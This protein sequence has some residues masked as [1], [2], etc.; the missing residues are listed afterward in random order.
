MPTISVSPE[1][2]YKGLGRTMTEKEFDKLC[3]DY[4][5]ELEVEREDEEG[6]PSETGKLVYKVEIPA[7]RY[8][9]LCLEGLVRAL[10]VYLGDIEAPRF[11]HV[12]M[13]PEDMQQLTITP[14]TQSVRPFCVAA[15]LRGVEF[16]QD[17]Y[18]RFIDLQDKLHQNICRRRALVAIGTHDLATITGPFVYDAQKP[19]D[20][21]FVPLR[22]PKKDE[23]GNATN[24]TEVPTREYTAA[25]LM[26]E[27]EKDQQLKQYLHI[28][29][30]EEVYPVIRDANGVVL[31]LPPIINGNHSRITLDTKDVFIECTATDL[32]RAKIVLNMMVTMLPAKSIEPVHVTPPN[33]QE[34][35]VYPEFKYRTEKVSAGDIYRRMGIKKE[36]AT[37]EQLAALLTKMQLRGKLVDADAIEVEIPPTRPD[38]LHACDIWE[39]AAVAFGFD[40]IQA[41]QPQ[42][43]TAGKQQPI[44]K[45]SDHLRLITAQAGYAEALTFALCTRDDNFKNLRRPDDGKTACVIANPKTK[46]FQVA[47]TNLLAGLLRT[48]HN[49]S[50]MPLPIQLFEISDVVLLDPSSD[51]GASNE[52]RLAAVAMGKS[53]RFEALQGLL[54]YI[55]KMLE[56]PFDPSAVNPGSKAYCLLP[57]QDPAFLGELG[58]ADIVYNGARV[59]V[60][61]VVHPEVLQNFDLRYPVSAFELAVHPFL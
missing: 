60:L 18:E 6:R 24:E 40:N 32:T 30:D 12:D 42:V 1:A 39:D 16:T 59:G 9:L 20:I 27:Y 61:G 37:P 31:S 36:Q 22:V 10:R 17:V 3:F 28:I 13:K 50:A 29:K 34:S 11:K 7:N 45:L 26:V 41:T 53:P 52:R 54:D 2:L 56:I 8:D 14:A 51:S 49:N 48:L 38:I 23:N 4:G 46:D 21:S 44:N 33:G 5:L 35:H 25:E 15:I 57:T 19:S 43:V 55:M 58:A 47:R